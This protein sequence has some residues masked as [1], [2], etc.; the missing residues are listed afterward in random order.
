MYLLSLRSYINIYSTSEQGRGVGQKPCWVLSVQ[1]MKDAK[2]QEE[3][4]RDPMCARSRTLDDS[5]VRCWSRPSYFVPLWQCFARIA[6]NILMAHTS[7]Q[8]VCVRACVFSSMTYFLLY[9]TKGVIYGTSCSS[10]HN[11]SERCHWL[12]SDIFKATFY[13]FSL[14]FT[15]IAYG[16]NSFSELFMIFFGAWQ[17][18]VG[19]NFQCMEVFCAG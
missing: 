17:C 14:F 2:R 6:S 16:F 7:T 4:R 3:T 19:L 11:E 13:D 5:H 18:P 12:S 9:N 8:L 1:Y 15:S 10:S